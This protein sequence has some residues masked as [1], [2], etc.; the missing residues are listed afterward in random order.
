MKIDINYINLGSSNGTTLIKFK[1]NIFQDKQDFEIF[2]RI[3]SDLCM[4]Y[5]FMGSS[6][7]EKSFDDFLFSLKNNY[8]YIV[9]ISY[10]GISYGKY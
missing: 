3:C 8:D 6:F 7:Y 2:K 9:T 10:E 1:K 5:D 4:S